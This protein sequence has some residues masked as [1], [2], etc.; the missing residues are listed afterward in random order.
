VQLDHLALHLRRRRPW[1][2]I[3]L[4]CRMAQTW[5]RPVMTAWLAVYVPTAIILYTIFHGRAAF[6]VAILWW[7]KPLFDRIVLEVLSRA[8]FG[9]APSLR[10]VLRAVRDSRGMLASLTIRRFDLA[11]SFNLPVWQLERLTG[12][13]ARERSRSLQRRTRNP[14]VWT[15]IVFAHL[16][17]ITLLALFGVIDLLT[18]VE[19][20]TDFGLKS[21]FWGDDAPLWRQ[22]LAAS[23][24][25]MTVSLIEPFYVASGF[26][27]YLN[28]RTQL[29]AWDLELT[30][31]GIARV[32]RKAP[33]RGAIAAMLLVA[34]VLSFAAPPPAGAAAREPQA[35]IKEV[36]AEKEFQQYRETKRWRW[37]GSDD[38][39]KVPEKPSTIGVPIAEIGRILMWIAAVALVGLLLYHARR[40]VG[41][42]APEI[43]RRETPSVLFG[44]DVTPESLPP[45][46]AAAALRAIEAG[47]AREALGL[48]YRGAL[49]ALVTRDGLE[50]EAGDTE[51]DCVRRTRALVEAD[52]ATVFASLVAAWQATAYARRPP[53]EDALRELWASWRAQFAAGER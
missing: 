5:W 47:H 14:A 37:R 42:W 10:A 41:A 28:R 19:Y 39:E 32:D 46:I 34:L 25:V 53:R 12:K 49:S 52:K 29:E 18:P 35:A 48:M 44:L 1:E 30:L 11:R 3:D 36:L 40:Y 50:V 26:A 6:A 20:D 15:T 23:F 4:G 31:R 2:A 27:L 33:R 51:G 7:L 8:V 13:A 9:E 21:L 24:D 45:D 17:I 22:M 38:D 16:Q 43:K